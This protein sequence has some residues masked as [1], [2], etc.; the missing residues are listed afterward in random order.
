MSKLRKYTVKKK[1]AFHG[2][3]CKLHPNKSDLPKKSAIQPWPFAL[4][5]LKATPY[6]PRTLLE[7]LLISKPMIFKLIADSRLGEHDLS[8]QPLAVLSV[9][10][11]LM[12]IL[13]LL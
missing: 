10:S 5:I 9:G 1:Y 12:Y 6:N 8:L 7:G 3:F 11:A 4:L 13:I 2:V